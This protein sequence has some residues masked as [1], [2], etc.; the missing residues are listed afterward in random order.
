M[1]IYH[2][3]RVNCFLSLFLEVGRHLA[4]CIFYSLRKSILFFKQKF[5]NLQCLLPKCHHLWFYMK[6]LCHSMTILAW[7]TLLMKS[8]LPWCLLWSFQNLWSETS[9]REQVTQ[10]CDSLPSKLDRIGYMHRKCVL[11]IKWCFLCWTM[12]LLL[13]FNYGKMLACKNSKHPHFKP[14][15]H[16]L[17]HYLFMN[18]CVYVKLFL[19]S[20]RVGCSHHRS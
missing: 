7:G 6:L 18:I 12:V 19:D 20:L 3:E 17:Y 13:F 11:N 4:I 1:K 5:V 2:T 14:L 8:S 9:G 15:L 16:L 10:L